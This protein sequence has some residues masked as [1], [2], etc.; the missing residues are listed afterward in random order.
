MYVSPVCRFVLLSLSSSGVTCLFAAEGG[1]L[2][3]G[4]QDGG[5]PH[6]YTGKKGG[7][8]VYV[9]RGVDFCLVKEINTS[10]YANKEIKQIKGFESKLI[11]AT[12]QE[13]F[14]VDPLTG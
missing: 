13:Y 3:G 8:G 6:L 12:I 2:G 1:P 14:L 10:A 9:Q 11:A 5:S 4:P 7:I